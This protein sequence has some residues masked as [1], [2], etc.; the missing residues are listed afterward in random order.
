MA[1][2]ESIDHFGPILHTDY[3]VQKIDN[4]YS[5]CHITHSSYS[6]A[7]LLP[8][9]ASLFVD[10]DNL[11]RYLEEIA[12]ITAE[13]LRQKEQERELRET[14]S[15]AEKKKRQ[16]NMKVCF[17]IQWQHVLRDRENAV[18]DLMII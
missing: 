12:D 11:I 17:L 7:E 15:S 8:Y 1:K 4:S 16:L 5:C 13:K 18:M 10:H 14:L 9:L 2:A 3:V 6:N